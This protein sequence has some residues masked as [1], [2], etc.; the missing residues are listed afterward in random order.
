MQGG[1]NC[2]EGEMKLKIL[3]FILGALTGYFIAFPQYDLIISSAAA[4]LLGT[5]TTGIVYLLE[6]YI[7]NYSAK[8]F[9]GAAIG[10]A[11]ASFAFFAARD[12]ISGFSLPPG[13]APYISAAFFLVLFQLGITIGYRKGREIEQSGRRPH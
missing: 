11:A 10:A 4:L 6:S 7:K 12:V 1:W 3:F 2:G 13:A 8:S 5:L 9:L